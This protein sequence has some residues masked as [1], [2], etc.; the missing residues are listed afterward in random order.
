M[1]TKILT[2]AYVLTTLYCWGYPNMTPG[3][4]IGS[5]ILNAAIFYAGYRILILLKIKGDEDND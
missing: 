2:I 1:K 5:A 3:R 4:M